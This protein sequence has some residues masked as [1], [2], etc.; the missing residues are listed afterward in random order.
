MRA[1]GA[2][3]GGTI[4]DVALAVCAGALRAYLKELGQL[5]R[6]SL[7]CLV[8]VSLRREGD[9]AAGNTA[10]AMS[11]TLATDIA[12]PL[13]RLA[14]ITAATRAGKESLRKSTSPAAATLHGLL[15]LLPL[16]I[17][18]SSGAFLLGRPPFNLVV[19]NVPTVQHKLYVH[20]A[21]LVRIVPDFLLSHGLALSIL[22]TSYGDQL[23]I[24]VTACPD[25]LPSVGRLRALLEA[26]FAL[27]EA[28][29]ARRSRTRRRSPRVAARR[30]LP[31]ACAR[32]AR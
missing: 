24:S 16:A 3:V 20:G 14:A 11:V 10:S 9:A 2:A 1:V 22:L 25:T 8:P 26:S 13:K 21:E 7:R 5:P 15:L 4:N 12:D 18:R 28:A 19:S 29:V 6:E 23:S 17:E 31:T 27:S 30:R 32:S